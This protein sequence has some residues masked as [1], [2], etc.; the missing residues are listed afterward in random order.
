[1]AKKVDLLV[2][3]TNY[4]CNFSNLAIEATQ[5][6]LRSLARQSFLQKLSHFDLEHFKIWKIKSLKLDTNTHLNLLR[7]SKWL[8]FFLNKSTKHFSLFLRY[9]MTTDKIESRFNQTTVNWFISW[10][11]FACKQYKQFTNCLQLSSNII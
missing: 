8:F 10:I 7:N 1:M 3:N 9:Y 5:K 4:W 2:Q 11:I 6:S